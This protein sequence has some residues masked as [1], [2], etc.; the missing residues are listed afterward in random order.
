MSKASLEKGLLKV[1][2]GAKG[3]HSIARLTSVLLSNVW[4]WECYQI[5]G[6]E[7]QTELLAATDFISDHGGHLTICLC[8]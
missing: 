5:T 4:C 8:L 7:K 6:L 2:H 3:L 1:Y